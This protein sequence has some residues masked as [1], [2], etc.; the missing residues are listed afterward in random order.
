M[1]QQLRIIHRVLSWSDRV[2]IPTLIFEKCRETA[3]LSSE[4]Q[5]TPALTPISSQ[6]TFG[7][8][9]GILAP[10]TEPR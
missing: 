5:E 2:L 10:W 4:S 7:L 9:R 8:L 6:P 1:L 3:H